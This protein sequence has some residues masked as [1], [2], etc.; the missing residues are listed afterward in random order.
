M[1]IFNTV[2]LNEYLCHVKSMNYNH[3]EPSSNFDTT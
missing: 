1:V 2:S 3:R